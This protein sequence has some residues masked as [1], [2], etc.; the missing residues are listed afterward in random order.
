MAIPYQSVGYGSQFLIQLPAK[1]PKKTEEDGPSNWPLKPTWGTQ[2]D[3]LAP[4]F[5]LKS[6]DKIP[7][8]LLH[9]PSLFLLYITSKQIIFLK[10]ILP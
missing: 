8:S 6:T 3:F 9:S 1:V 10:K 5:S 4:A 7:L 2:I